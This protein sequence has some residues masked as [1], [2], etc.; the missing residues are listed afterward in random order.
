MKRSTFYLTSDR[1]FNTT[2][3][4]SRSASDFRICSCCGSMGD[5]SPASTA[6]AAFADLGLMRNLSDVSA[7][8]FNCFFLSSFFSATSLSRWARKYS[9]RFFSSLA[10]IWKR[11]QQQQNLLK[12][13]VTDTSLD[14]ASGSLVA[15][16]GGFF[17]STGFSIMGSFSVAFSSSDVLGV[18]ESDRS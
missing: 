12:L 14:F 6:S 10:S 18:A 8:A 17:S 3:D 9:W 7:S 2:S 16:F 13:M 11:Q 4:F 5:L 1:V 15:G